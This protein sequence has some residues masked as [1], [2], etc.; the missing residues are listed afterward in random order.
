[1]E[2][3]PVPLSTKAGSLARLS[4]RVRTAE[5]LPLDYCDHAEWEEDRDGVVRRIMARP[6]ANDALIV[7]S[8]ALGEDSATSSQA[9]KY[10]SVPR[11][12]GPQELVVAVDKVFASYGEARPGDQV[13]VQPEL[14]DVRESGVACTHEPTNGAPYTV[15]SWSELPDTSVVTA[16]RAGDL[17]TW[18]GAAYT[19]HEIREPGPVHGVLGL[20][21]ELRELTGEQRLD[22]E[23]AVTAAGMLVLLQVRPL[24]C[25]SDDIGE[26]EHHALLTTAADAVVTATHTPAGGLGARTAYGVMPDWN[27]AE[28]IGLRPHPLALSLY[29]ELITDEVWSRARYRYGYRDLRG[30]PLLVDVCGLPYVDVRAS[31]SS[32]IPRTLSSGLAARLVE[33]WVERLLA[34]PHLHDKLESRIV[35]SSLGLRRPGRLDGLRRAGL[36][37]PDVRRLGEALRQLTDSVLSGPL[38]TE[39]LRR[40]ESLRG[41][42]PNAPGVAGMLARLDF[43]AEHGTLPFAGLARAAFIATELLDDLVVEGVFTEDERSRLIGGLGLVSGELSRDFHMLRQEEFLARYGHL[44]PGT[45]DIRSLRYDEDPG[46]YFDWS[47]RTPAPERPALRPSRAQLGRIDKLL[48]RGGLSVDAHRLLEFIASSIRGRELAKFEFSRVLSDVLSEVRRLGEDQGRTAADMSYLDVATL[49][50]LTGDPADDEA[51]LTDAIAHG[52]A[53]YERTRRIALPPLLSGPDDVWSFT[54]SSVQPTFVTQSRV[55]ARVANV[56]AG[57]RPD[58]AIALV[59][60]ADPGYDWLFA[61]GIAGLITAFGGVNSHMAIRAIELGIPAVIGAG[62]HQFRQWSRA[63][64]LD[65]DAANRH[66]AVIA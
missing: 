13:L 50:R 34:N 59:S 31:V 9:G 45:Y 64:A 58:G 18:Y 25:V 61:R 4:G 23:F 41:G 37:E 40:I 36:A 63:T 35:I 3:E 7:R 62:E 47:A 49:R 11:V 66:V 22:V 51:L 46:H 53:S 19:G 24:A 27:P 57:D 17:R 38:W 43:C 32:L 14:V 44:R 52:R 16:G 1:M 42:V 28:M 30:T 6:W 54:L 48:K 33:T 5:I 60:S 56:D 2:G 12:R 15:V 10:L 20:L 8:S 39:E 65:L 26:A 21:A 55:R 29:R